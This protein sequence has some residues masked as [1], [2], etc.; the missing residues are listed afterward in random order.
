VTVH[1][2][3]QTIARF[4]LRARRIEA[5]SLVR[6][7][8]QLTQHAQGSFRVHLDVSGPVSFT[9]TLPGDEEAFES[10]AAR[11]RPLML[12]SEPIHCLKVVTAL[13]RL[14]DC[15][16]DATDEHRSRL[17]KLR[18]AWQAAELQGS[19]IQAYAVQSM[20]LDGSDAP[21]MVSD[22]QLAAGWLYAD[23]IHADPTG[24][25]QQVMRFSLRE[26]YAAAVRVF[27][28]I[29][30]LAVSTLRL[31]EDLR[32][33]GVL[34]IPEHVWNQDVVVGAS[35]LVEQ[36]TALI[37][38]AGSAPPDL[39]DPQF[40]LTG[41]WKPFTVTELLRRDPANHVRVG[42]I[43]RDGSLVADYDA[44]VARRQAEGD[45]LYWQVLI[46][47]SFMIQVEFSTASDTAVRAVGVQ[48]TAFDSTNRLILAS[49]LLLLQMQ[50]ADTVVFEVAGQPF[51]TLSP[52]R[53]DDHA[54][55][56]IQVHSET[57]ADIVAMESLSGQEFAPCNAPYDNVGRVHLRQARLL[58]EGHIVG[59]YRKPVRTTVP[60][61]IPPQVLVCEPGTLIVGGSH[62]P[63]P[64][65]LLRHPAMDQPRSRTRAT[66]QPA[67]PHLRGRCARR[68]TVARLVPPTPHRDTGRQPG[69]NRIMGSHR[70]R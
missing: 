18:G 43:R 50:E 9:R 3:E 44:A 54:R 38:P 68:G 36:G 62:V 17:D 42:L 12:K 11:V 56:Q 66:D 27:S 35:E 53:L 23:L 5:H 20:R 6:D 59:A 70:H 69:D 40:G 32:S 67:G 22:T 33:A 29:A 10:L 57:A 46:A 47:G 19:Q 28:R 55:R 63:T 58:S 25:K 64:L 2:D 1:N 45:V 30:A 4:V 16:A 60:N 51:L 49:H 39:R 65:M 8:D 15:S 34:S 41:D 52:P 7:W 31:V 14:M 21:P 61:G 48:W 26:R 13:Q 37:A 24:P